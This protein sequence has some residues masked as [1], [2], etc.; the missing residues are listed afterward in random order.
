VKKKIILEILFL[1]VA[2]LIIVPAL[3][4]IWMHITGKT[5]SQVLYR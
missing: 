1:I 5:V 2:A 4:I 3:T